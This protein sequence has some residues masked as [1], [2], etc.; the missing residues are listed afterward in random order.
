[1][2]WNNNK[3]TISMAVEFIKL[4]A[5]LLVCSK[6]VAYVATVVVDVVVAPI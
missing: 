4:S 3:Y 1:M 6:Q 2:Q 5:F